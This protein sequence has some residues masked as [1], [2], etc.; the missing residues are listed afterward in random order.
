MSRPG[1]DAAEMAA[2]RRSRNCPCLNSPARAEDVVPADFLPTPRPAKVAADAA[3]TPRLAVNAAATP[4]RREQGEDGPVKPPPLRRIDAELAA[5]TRRRRARE[6][7]AAATLVKPRRIDEAL[8]PMRARRDEE[9]DAATRRRR[10]ADRLAEGPMVGPALGPALGANRRRPMDRRSGVDVA[11]KA[12]PAPDEAPPAVE[13]VAPPKRPQ[14]P[15]IVA[16]RQTAAAEVRR[17]GVAEVRRTE[18]VVVRQTEAVVVRQTVEEVVRQT[19]AVVVRQTAAERTAAV[20]VALDE[21]GVEEAEEDVAGDVDAAP[22]PNR[23]P[24]IP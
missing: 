24:R 11:R 3:R 20:A 8:L 23:P 22:R 2:A 17:T 6:E 5:A 13:I 21:E 7:D 9:A 12:R 14:T 4:P 1:E 10:P 16:A 19:E 15:E 18:A